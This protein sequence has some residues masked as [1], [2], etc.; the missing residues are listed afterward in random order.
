VVPGLSAPGKLLGDGL[1]PVTLIVKSAAL[2][3][4]PLSFTTC[5]ITCSVASCVVRLP[6]WMKTFESNA[7]SLP[8]AIAS[9]M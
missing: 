2:A 5:L 3:E 4:P 7:K 9:F 8:S 1:V 6:R